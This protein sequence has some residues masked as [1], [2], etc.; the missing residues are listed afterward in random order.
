MESL[1]ETQRGEGDPEADQERADFAMDAEP[2]R[3]DPEARLERR[4]GK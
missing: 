4:E 3:E 1:G 2:D